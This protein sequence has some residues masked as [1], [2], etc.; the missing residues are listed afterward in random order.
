MWLDGW[1]RVRSEEKDSEDR[2]VGAR[3]QIIIGQRLATFF[4][5]GSDT[6]HFRL[7]KA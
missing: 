1:S 4:F 2:G 6:K 3:G 5:K 7:F